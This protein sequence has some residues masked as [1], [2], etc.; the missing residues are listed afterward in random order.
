[1]TWIS[2]H[3]GVL[4][5]AQARKIV[6][7]CARALGSATRALRAHAIAAIRAEHT[8]R[9]RNLRGDVGLLTSLCCSIVCDLRGQGWGMRVRGRR[10]EM[11]PP[12]YEDGSP[13][14]RKEQVRAA[15]LLERDAQLL[16]PP[17]RLFI[18][19]MERRR[20]H[21]GNW[22]SIFSLM[23]D[24]RDLAA[25]LRRVVAVPAGPLRS[26]ALRQC[27]DPYVQ[28]VRGDDIC[29]FT[30]LRLVDVWRYFRHTWTT[31]YLSTPGRKMWFLVR[32]R[33]APNHPVIGIGA[34]GSA[35]VQLTPRDCWIGWTPSEFL[36]G[37]KAAPTVRWARWLHRSLSQLFEAVY[38]RD[39]LSEGIVDRTL[40]RRP[41]SDAVARLRRFAAEERRLH[42]LYPKR[43][44][45]KAAAS[46]GA[47]TD[48]AAE[49]RS[50]LFRAKRAGML[51]DLLDARRRLLGAGFTKPTLG[52]LKRALGKRVS[53]RAIRTILRYVKG[54][55][56][57][58]DMMDITVC[59]AIAPYNAV[60]GGKLIALLMASPDVV[61]PYRERYRS[62]VSVIASAMAGRAVRRRPNLVL[63]S[64]TSL[65]EVAPAQYNRLRMPASL[66]GGRDDNELSFIKL[67][68]T[69]GFGSYHF[70]RETM[71]TLELVLA[72]SHSGRPVN[73][74]FGEGV[75]P[76]LRKVRTALDLLGM[77]SDALLQHRSR[78]VIYAV[79]LARNF[80]DVLLG[81]TARP[82]PIIPPRPA[83][84]AA[85]VD[86]WR[87]R[88]FSNRIEREETIRAVATHS[89]A[90][91]IHHGA[92][93]A[94]P[95]ATDEEGP[96]FADAL[97][98][99]STDTDRAL[100]VTQ[101]ADADR[102]VP[103]AAAA[104]LA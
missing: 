98:L 38:M 28:L 57:G 69:V 99:P 47:M 89:L 103:A 49:A 51:A 40:L 41:T 77:P 50:H 75:N 2:F 7:D 100:P 72:R 85:I 95:R 42:Q 36:G 59:G 90:Y 15:H 23:R 67:G 12:D 61:T 54:A 94:L 8:Q 5:D 104:S 53:D 13:E 64:T 39:L 20:L 31:S 84:T 63:L 19:E 76:K 79:P 46:G 25:Q 93:V 43:Q 80:R 86:F 21:G 83:A 29:E 27:I 55:H 97:L 70:S 88:W 11:A 1:V 56:V 17:T 48:W 81:L 26:Q 37:L 96:L 87:D 78:R 34:L 3:P 22:C 101:L 33:A 65:Y 73:S 44:E 18:R 66:A 10:V 82:D 14:D 24:G 4:K 74:I 91:P 45:H 102:D 30:G 6:R 16:Q 60:L 62:A 68:R 32:D 52:D 58:V 9:S 92:R 71:A 35:V